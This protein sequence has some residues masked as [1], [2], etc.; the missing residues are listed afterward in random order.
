M[1]AAG[2]IPADLAQLAELAGELSA[3]A[4]AAVRAAAGGGAVRSKSSPTDPATAA[5]LAADAAVRAVLAEARPRD[6]VYSEEGREH[7]S[8]SG[9]RWV[10][11]PLDGTVNHLHR[12]PHRAVSVA[13][14]SD[15]DGGWQA[16]VG[17]VLDIDRRE[18]FTAARGSGSRLGGQP[19]AVADPVPLRQALIGTGFGYRTEVRRRQGTQVARLLPAVA[20]LRSSG[21]TALD[22]CWTAA[23][24]LD[25]YFE[26]DLG[27]WDW[28]AG[29]LIVEQAG[30]RVSEHGNGVLAAGPSLHI[31]LRDLL[32]PSSG[33]RPGPDGREH[34]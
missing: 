23:G 21:S 34:R 27:R 14:E 15:V 4:A 26:D 18:R 25:G 33:P 32:E 10:I 11:D 17:V 2:P 24:R 22:L 19:I 8:R 5:D 29:R 28:A 7:P 9:F 13:C 16:V 6:G 20:D 30:G 12:I 3:R 31:R 1:A